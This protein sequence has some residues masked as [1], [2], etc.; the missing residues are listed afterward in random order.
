MYINIQQNVLN[1][2]YCTLSLTCPPRTGPVIINKICLSV[3]KL[4]LFHRRR[5]CW[6]NF[7]RGANPPHFPLSMERDFSDRKTKRRD[8]LT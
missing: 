3:T 4:S 1:H 7:S 8:L 2:L 6:P 5:S